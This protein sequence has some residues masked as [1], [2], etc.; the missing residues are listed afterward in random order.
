M[1][2]SSPNANRSIFKTLKVILDSDTFLSVL[3]MSKI[4]GFG[5]RMSQR[6]VEVLS[7]VGIIKRVNKTEGK[8]Y[9]YIR[10]IE[11]ISASKDMSPAQRRCYEP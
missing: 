6:H 11:F 7:D 2:K 10:N 3:D 1:Q 8:G 9:L 4:T 5:V